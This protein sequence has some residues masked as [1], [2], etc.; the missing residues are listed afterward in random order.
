MGYLGHL[1][2]RFHSSWWDELRP[3]SLNNFCIHETVVLSAQTQEKLESKSHIYKSWNNA[4]FTSAC[5]FL[6]IVWCCF[7]KKKVPLKTLLSFCSQFYSCVLK[8]H[9]LLENNVQ[10]ISVQATWKTSENTVP[11]CEMTA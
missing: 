7:F 9:H 4:N 3:K 8:S 1:Q 11:F 6:N 5:I 2:I 10:N